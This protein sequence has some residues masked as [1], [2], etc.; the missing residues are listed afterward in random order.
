MKKYQRNIIVIILILTGITLLISFIVPYINS[1]ND[2]IISIQNNSTVFLSF[3]T[4]LY[5]L[6]TYLILSSSVKSSEEQLRPYIVVTFPIIH[7]DV[8]FIIKNIGKRPAH[9]INIEI[10]PPIDSIQM[11][12][13]KGNCTPMLT[14]Y[15]LAPNQELKNFITTTPYILKD[16]FD[17]PEL[18]EIEITYFDSTG[19]LYTEMHKTNFNS[20]TYKGKIIN[21]DNNDYL[22]GIEK[23]L[24]EI[25]K[26][27][28][29]R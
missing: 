16:N 1:S 6:I 29:K 7:L 11:E 13:F 5:V 21:R 27:L 17:I 2:A 22:K 24:K 14:Q 18:F 10:S 15:F 4:F 8:Y 19:I 20:L 23:Y 25:S 12:S 9:N 3:L 26:N 28:E